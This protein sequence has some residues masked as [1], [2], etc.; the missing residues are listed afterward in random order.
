MGLLHSADID[1][2]CSS[3]LLTLCGMLGADM[4]TDLLISDATALH[5]GLLTDSFP[6][7]PLMQKR[8]LSSYDTDSDK[9][10]LVNICSKSLTNKSE[11]AVLSA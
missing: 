5:H 10:K 7:K 4:F 8:M 2:N 9:S 1:K 3:L 6:A 11:S